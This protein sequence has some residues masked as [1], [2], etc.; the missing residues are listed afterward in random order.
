MLIKGQD[1]E[2]ITPLST[3]EFDKTNGI[4]FRFII[5]NPPFGES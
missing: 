3:L 5:E 1:P 4:K 2:R